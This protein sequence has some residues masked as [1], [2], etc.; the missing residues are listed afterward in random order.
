MLKMKHIL[1]SQFW[2]QEVESTRS[3]E[4]VARTLP[5]EPPPLGITQGS[6]ISRA[7]QLLLLQRFLPVPFTPSY[8][9]DNDD[10]GGLVLDRVLASAGGMDCKNP[11]VGAAEAGAAAAGVYI[12]T[13]HL[14]LQLHERLESKPNLAPS[15]MKKHAATVEAALHERCV[16]REGRYWDVPQSLSLDLLSLGAPGGLRYRL[17]GCDK[18][19]DVK[20]VPFGAL[21]GTR[22]QA[23]L[24]LERQVSVWK[25]PT[26][27]KKPYNLLAA[28]PRL[29]FAGML[30]GLLSA[31]LN[32]RSDVEAPGV[33]SRR[34]LSH[35]KPLAAD[36]FASFGATAQLGLFERRFLDHTLV[37]GRVDLG[38]ASAFAA[39]VSQSSSLRPSAGA[40]SEDHQKLEER[41]YPTVA[42]TMQQQIYGPVRARVDTRYALAPFSSPRGVERPRTLE[43]TYGLDCSLE[44]SGA[45]RLVVWY[46]PT[47]REGMVEVRIL[48]Q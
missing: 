25:D 10:G 34:A 44:K 13:K 35:V 29:T 28:R 48:D 16:D 4:A 27:S 2:N 11:P 39:A 45:A 36:L 31:N 26:R 37:S 17:G 24:S 7:Q 3:L 41:G 22:A 8:A 9:V 47:R 33:P 18:T 40:A 14:T 23:A 19:I 46:S 21:P 12:R 43:C 1:A 30:G 32:P 42:L 38:A 15:S 20:A 5:S 6:R